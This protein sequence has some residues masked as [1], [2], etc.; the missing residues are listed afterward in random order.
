PIAKRQVPHERAHD[1]YLQIVQEFLQLDNPLQI[2]DP[3]FGLLGNAA[4]AGGVPE[5]SDINLDCLHQ[6]TAD[7][8]FTNAKAISDVRGM[9][10]ALVFQAIERN[11]GLVGLASVLCDE[12]A[13]NPEIA[14]F[15]QHQDAASEG[16]LE[17]NQAIAPELAKQ[18]AL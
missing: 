16:A 13:V 8:A 9:A 14:A 3:V 18:L 2:L 5:D 6:L 1:L 12:E 15:P 17:I 7:Q 11:T 4:A 10:A